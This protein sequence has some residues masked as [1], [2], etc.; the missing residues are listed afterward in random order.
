[1]E[2][3][4]AVEE[5]KRRVYEKIGKNL[6]ILQMIESALKVLVA[7]RQYEGPISQAQEI[8]NKEYA[9]V[10]KQTMGMLAAALN[11]IFIPVSDDS[12]SPIN[13]Q[14]PYFS[15]FFNIESNTRSLDSIARELEVVV[16]ERNHLVHHFFSQS[17]L[18]TNEDWLNS[19]IRLDAQRV[20]LIST[21]E[22][23]KSL[24]NALKESGDVLSRFLQ[25][26]YGKKIF[27][28]DRQD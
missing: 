11:Q 1:M 2:N 4:E 28:E 3:Q 13:A 26:E 23:L 15:F 14:E 12:R 25:S 9:S 27:L 19:E 22:Y 18:K 21:F 6:H 20:Q 17:I 8:K 5:I 10:S 7:N 24:V 16:S